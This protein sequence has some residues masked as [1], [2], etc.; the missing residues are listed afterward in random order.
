MFQDWPH[1]ARSDQ[2]NAIKAY[3]ILRLSH[4]ILICRDGVVCFSIVV[5]QSRAAKH[6]PTANPIGSLDS[7]LVVMVS[8]VN[9][10]RY[11]PDS[12]VH[13]AQL[14]ALTV[15]SSNCPATVGHQ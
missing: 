7:F 15:D 10:M 14:S 6:R 8:H 3:R 1:V 9:G 2:I 13:T 12:G 11:G 5:T 4:D